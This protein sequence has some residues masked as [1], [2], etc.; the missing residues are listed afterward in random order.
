[1]EASKDNNNNHNHN[2]SNS[3]M[4]KKQSKRQRKFQATGGV[5]GR[6]ERGQHLLGGKHSKGGGAGAKNRKRQPPSRSGG[7]AMAND[8]SAQAAKRQRA[9][10]STEAKSDAH[11]RP[12]NLLSRENLGDLDMDS[13]FRQF[14]PSHENDGDDDDDSNAEDDDDDGDASS[15]DDNSDNDDSDQQRDARKE[16][17]AAKDPKKKGGEPAAAASSS[18][19]SSDSSDSDDDGDGD[20]DR[21]ASAADDDDEDDDIEAAERSLRAEMSKMKRSDPEFHEFLME[22][23]ESLLAFGEEDEDD[24][25]VAADD[26]ADADEEKV[27]KGQSSPS[28]R[29][30]EIPL[31]PQLLSSLARGAFQHHGVKTLKK[32]VAAYR[33]AC[34]LSEAADTDNDNNN[35]PL[36]RRSGESSRQQQQLLYH[37]DSS[38][39]F[40]DLMV[41][42]L[43]R[44]H[45]E[46]HHHLLLDG[47]KKETESGGKK[48]DED[49]GSEEEAAA[50]KEEEDEDEENK[51][52]NPK[53][54]EKAARWNDLRPILMSFFRST[55]HVLE[56]AKEPELLTFVLKALAKYMRYLTPFP[57]IAESMLKSMTALWSAP[58][59]ASESYQ[60]VRVHAFLRIRQLALTQPFPFIEECLKKTYLAYAKRAKFAGSSQ[61]SLPALTFMGNCLVELYSLDFDSS[62]QHAFVYIRQ[63]ALFLRTALQK[64]TPEAMQQVYC[65]QYLQCLKLWVAVLSQAAP[66]DDGQ[67]MRSLVYPLTEIILGTVRLVPSPVRHLPFR[68]HCVRLLQQ[69]AAASEVFIPTTALLLDCLDWKEWTLPPKKS[70]ARDAT[71]GVQLHFLLKLGKDDPLRTHEQLE[72]AAAEFFA[73]LQREIELYRYSAGFPEFS[74]R[75]VAR[76]R[77]FVKETRNPR[78]RAHARACLDLCDKYSKFAIQERSK[79]QEAP[80]D[81][82]RLECLKPVSEKSMRE[83]HQLAID[84]ENAILEASRPVTSAK[85]ND[86]PTEC[87]EDSDASEVSEEEEK[88]PI[89]KKKS[90]KHKK[91][92]PVNQEELEKQMLDRDALM[93]EQDQVEEGVDWLDD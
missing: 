44:C 58:L 30:T 92:K 23:E 37:I 26:D 28:T 14:A 35:K 81:V 61:H 82:K 83:R 11:R 55:L 17:T 63:L 76:L 59:E 2:N 36:L 73:L 12:D 6:L 46:F 43:S 45:E 74:I 87:D 9:A 86:K 54:L 56:D 65:W 10:E 31:T 27:G 78:F 66:A 18:S 47:K 64:K 4:G 60:V 70:R 77:H 67:M 5:R 75:I 85:T 80:R 50:A 93:E 13:F 25:E 1:M 84:K 42:C 51:P 20:A 3:A 71:R 90:R 49:E 38:Q 22:N 19:S 39:V 88:P 32:M 16:S 62:Y 40:D 57:R 69:L 15:N 41:L 21:A 89:K 68:F 79:L 8:P 48:E 72:A 53:V 7:D 24:E 91:K 34:H 52:I 33:S 29:Q